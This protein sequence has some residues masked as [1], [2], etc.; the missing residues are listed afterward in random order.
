MVEKRI[1]NVKAVL[2]GFR[3]RL[4]TKVR[5]RKMILFGSY[6]CGTPRDYSDVDVAVISPDFHGGT[7]ADYRLLGRAAREV[8]SL[9]EAFA[10]TPRDIKNCQPGD[11]LDHIIKTGK[12]VYSS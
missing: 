10:Y 3:E 8:N 2:K 5:V 1:K 9:I 6:A 7:K 12:I 11:F 4:Q